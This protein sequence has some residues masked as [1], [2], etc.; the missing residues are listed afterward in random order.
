MFSLSPIRVYTCPVKI[1]I[2]EKKKQYE[3]E[4]VINKTV[5]EKPRIEIHQTQKLSKPKR[6]RIKLRQQLFPQ[7]K[8]C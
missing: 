3:R 8:L 2:I 7:G 4:E 6:Q 5:I 1:I